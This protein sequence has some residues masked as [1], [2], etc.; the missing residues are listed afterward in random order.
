MPFRTEVVERLTAAAVAELAAY[1]R[2]TVARLNVAPELA[3]VL[4]D[5]RTEERNHYEALVK[6]IHQ[7]G[8]RPEAGVA[9]FVAGAPPVAGRALV[10]DLLD[11]ESA[12]V[13][14]YSGLC[15]F[16]EGGDPWTFEVVR[17]ILC[18]E[19]EHRAWLLEFAGERSEAR[20]RPGFRGRSPHLAR[21]AGVF[22]LTGI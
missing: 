11:T 1:H 6:R 19:I 17:A 12:A 14:Y 5:M 21:K 4:D 8:G 16:T 9:A 22:R 10:A 20:F 13:R 2:Y 7:L 3:A 18:E 15:A